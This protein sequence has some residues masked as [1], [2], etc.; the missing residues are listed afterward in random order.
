MRRPVG[1]LRPGDHAWL[2]FGDAD[3]RCH[4]L[5]SFVARGLAGA[6]KVIVL[7]GPGGAEPPGVGGRVTLLALDEIEPERLAATLEAE[8]SAAVDAG[9]RGVRVA[10]DLTWTLGRG[11][12]LRLLLECER[13]I[14]RAVG[15][16]TAAIAICQ[17]DR[18]CGAAALDALAD[19]HAVTVTAD[20]A[21]EDS[22]LRIDRTFRPVGLAVGGQL[23]AA[24]HAVFSEAL[25]STMARA[26]G[27]PVHL[28]LAGLEFIDLGALTM[29]ADA[30]ARC[31]G[32]VVLDRMPARLRAIIEVVGWDAL[33]GLRLG[34][35]ESGR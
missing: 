17:V 2:A 10:A 31:R 20:P 33:P 4:V 21:F 25:T 6:D 27:D 5:G 3:E 28:D 23:D 34:T 29:L 22:V 1:E 11:N 16:S 24:R 9:Y 13:Q 26:N 14:D 18:G 30:A 35:P 19:A 15:A 7:R 8:I 12:G 32:P